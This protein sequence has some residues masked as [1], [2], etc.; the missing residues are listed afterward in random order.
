MACN[1]R[2]EV[3]V[4]EFRY[5][6]IRLQ[7]ALGAGPE[8]HRLTGMVERVGGNE[9]RA[10]GSSEELIRLMACW[11]EATTDP[12]SGSEERDA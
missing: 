2:S 8:L 11:T 4:V 6:M 5:F 12:A 1:H 3:F 9:K 7:S 10:F